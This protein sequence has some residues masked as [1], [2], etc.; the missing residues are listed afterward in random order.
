MLK[1]KNK[2]FF[3]FIVVFLTSFLIQR[4]ILE[5]HA[6]PLTASKIVA[7]YLINGIF[8]YLFFLLIHFFLEKVKNYLG[9]IFIGFSLLKFVLFFIFIYPTYKLNG[10]ISSMEFTSFF[11]PYGICLLFEIVFLG[12]LLNNLKF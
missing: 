7:S 4:Y 9:F 5:K 6:I 8:V 2:L 10:A 11:I 12:K 1:L 3:G